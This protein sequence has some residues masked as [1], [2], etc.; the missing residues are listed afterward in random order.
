MPLA[1]SDFKSILDVVVNIAFLRP[2]A[3]GHRPLLIKVF[4]D[5]HFELFRFA[6]EKFRT[7]L[8][9]EKREEGDGAVSLPARPP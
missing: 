4:I 9:H 6:E 2:L 7:I 5:E 8:R 1:A 3:E